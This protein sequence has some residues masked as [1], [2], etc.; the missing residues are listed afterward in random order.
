MKSKDTFG[1]P[2]R[3]TRQKPESFSEIVKL[4]TEYYYPLDLNFDGEDWKFPDGKLPRKTPPE[5][6][7]LVAKIFKMK[8]QKHIGIRLN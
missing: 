8:L 3:K 4:I 7:E 5:I 1:F 6:D 2:V